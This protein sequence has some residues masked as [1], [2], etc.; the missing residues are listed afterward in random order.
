MK[1]EA[2]VSVDHDN[3]YFAHCPACGWEGED[4]TVKDVAEAEAV[5]HTDHEVLVERAQHLRHYYEDARGEV[6]SD[7]GYRRWLDSNS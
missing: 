2:H 1:H 3:N 6:T 7:E 4:T 5:A